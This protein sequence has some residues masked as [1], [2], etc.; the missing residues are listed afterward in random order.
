MVGCFRA[1]IDRFVLPSCGAEPG[2][3]VGG[4]GPLERMQF[5][6]REVLHVC[7]EMWDAWC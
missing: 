4:F 1:L 2:S 6:E 3:S 5:G 7:L